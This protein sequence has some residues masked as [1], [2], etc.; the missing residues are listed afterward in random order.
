MRRFEQTN[1]PLIWYWQWMTITDNH[2]RHTNGTVRRGHDRSIKC[3]M[4]CSTRVQNLIWI[5]GITHRHNNKRSSHR[6]NYK[7][8]ISSFWINTIKV[9]MFVTNL[10]SAFRKNTCRSLEQ[11]RLIWGLR[12][13][14]RSK[15]SKI[16]TIMTMTTTMFIMTM[17]LVFA[18]RLGWIRW[19]R[20]GSSSNHGNN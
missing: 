6:I 18:K 5:K 1:K 16:T 9:P 10:I 11:R 17:E 15:L 7:G 12:L 13:L 8:K 3:H 19:L 4:M 14:A 20:G 2:I